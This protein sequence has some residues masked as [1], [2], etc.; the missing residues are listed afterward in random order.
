LTEIEVCEA[1]AV[2][3]TCNWVWEYRISLLPD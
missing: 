2:C 1:R 3:C